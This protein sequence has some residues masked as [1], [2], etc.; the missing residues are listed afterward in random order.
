M[1]DCGSGVTRKKTVQLEE[2]IERLDSGTIKLI[3]VREPDEIEQMGSIPTS[4]NIPRMIYRFITREI[5]R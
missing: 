3:D 5:D 1:E 2:L 4:I